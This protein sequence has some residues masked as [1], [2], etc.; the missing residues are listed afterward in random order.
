[1]KKLS[2]LGLTIALFISLGANCL[3]WIAIA[4][5]GNEIDDVWFPFLHTHKYSDGQ[6]HDCIFIH[7]LHTPTHWD[8]IRLYLRKDLT[9]QSTTVELVET[10]NQTRAGIIIDQD[11]GRVSYGLNGSQYKGELL[12]QYSKN[13]CA[14][15]PRDGGKP[16]FG[17]ID[18]GDY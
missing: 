17:T 2:H 15:Y 16:V 7:E 3:F 10:N 5:S 1:M 12:M 9:T 6:V 14:F 18:I 13:Q 11:H 8:G 4:S